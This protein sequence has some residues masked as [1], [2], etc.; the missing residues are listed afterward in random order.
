MRDT[1]QSAENSQGSARS[2]AGQRLDTW[3]WA[4]RFFKT[5]HL[6]TEAIHGGKVLV[7]GVRGKPSRMVSQGTCLT[8]QR[9][10]LEWRITVLGLNSQRRPASEAQ[11]LYQE[12]PDSLEKRLAL[13][14]ERRLV[15]H[16]L[17]AGEGRPSKRDRR[18][19]HRFTQS[20]E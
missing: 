8:I 17:T 5:R 18:L 20:L 16:H 7:E 19:I 14:E 10:G 13:I 12:L 1:R 4:A 11:Q 2:S 3:L 15:G 6:A 9:E